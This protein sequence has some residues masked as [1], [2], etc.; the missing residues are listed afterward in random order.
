LKIAIEEATGSR[1]DINGGAN[2]VYDIA[3][4]AMEVYFKGIRV[5]SKILCNRWPNA[6]L[7]ASKCK[8]LL[9]ANNNGDDIMS[10]EHIVVKKQQ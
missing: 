8:R 4:G 9:D 1:V 3:V 5:Y 7:V 6:G 2:P 10:F